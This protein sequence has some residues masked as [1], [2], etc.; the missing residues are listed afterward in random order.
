MMA[1]SLAAPLVEAVQVA[2][3]F[4]QAMSKVQAITNADEADTKKLATTARDLGAKTKVFCNTG[5]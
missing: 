1:K 4:E 5:S 2:A 3:N